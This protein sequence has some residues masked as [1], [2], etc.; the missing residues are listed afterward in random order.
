MNTSTLAI[1]ALILASGLGGLAGVF[2]K[3]EVE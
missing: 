2:S 1:V 3:V